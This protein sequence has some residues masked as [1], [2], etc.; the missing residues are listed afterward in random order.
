MPDEV[1][2]SD[3]VKHYA[4]V[5]ALNGVSFSVEQGR[6]FGLLGRNGAG[7]TTAI[8]CIVGL[9]RPDRGSAIVHGIDAI[10]SPHRAR[11]FIGVQ[12]QA[13]ALQ[14]KITPRE[15]LR[16]FASFHKTSVP[17]DSLIERFFLA[18]KA[19][20]PFDSL[21]SGQRQRL[22]LALAIVN[23][24]RV[25]FLDEPTAGLDA[26]SRRQL[27]ETI[28]KMRTDGHTILLTTHYIEEAEELC[29]EI[30]ILHRGSIVAYGTPASLVDQQRGMSRIE[31]SAQNPVEEQWIR[32]L[33]STRDVQKCS[34]SWRF[35]T[36]SVA[37][38]V[39]ALVQKLDT[40][41]NR[42]ADLRVKGAGL[43]DV[44]VELTR[45]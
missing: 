45:D 25:L 34:D 3:L 6:I 27:H 14:D 39:S 4:S 41:G 29:D 33:P 40:E 11:Q 31:F 42:L 37:A 12:L 7:K 24:P 10:Q 36:D 13:T 8:E 22:A 28:L 16:L 43:E 32:L 20:A 17:A 30:A 2:V 21:S 23:E 15:A 5:G 9:R 38:T 44:F 1:I 35:C 18:E 26:Q 19:D